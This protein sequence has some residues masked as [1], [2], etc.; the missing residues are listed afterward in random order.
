[1]LKR[2]FTL[3]FNGLKQRRDDA[4]SRINHEGVIKDVYQEVEITP[5]YFLMLSL[6]NLIALTGLIV[7]SAPVIIGAML[8]S[9][10]MGPILSTGFAFATGNRTI[11]RRALRKVSVSVGLTLT[12]A[13]AASYL[14]PIQEITSEIA[15]RTRPNLFDLLIA[16][17]AGLAGAIAICTK[18]NYITIVPGVAIA[19]AVIPPLSVAGFGLG[20]GDFMVMAGG[21]FL[22]FT[23]FVAIIISTCGVLYFFGF[24]PAADSGLDRS[25]VRKRMTFLA[26]V[27]CVISVPLVYTL[28]RSVS[29]LGRKKTVMTALKSRFDRPGVSRLATFTLRDQAG[30]PIEIDAVINTIRYLSEREIDLAEKGIRASFGQPV[31]LNLEQIRVQPGGLKEETQVKPLITPVQMKPRLPAEIVTDAR[32]ELMP[33]LKAATER[34]TGVISPAV[35]TGFS[36]GFSSRGSGTYLALRIN[37][38]YPLSGD[39]ARLLENLVS[40]E[41]GVPV[42]LRVETVPFVPALVFQGDAVAITDEMGRTLLAAR[43]VFERAPDMTVTVATWPAYPANRERNRLAARRRAESVALFLTENCKIPRDRIRI[44]A[45][46]P[47]KGAGPAV[48]VRILPPDYL[49]QKPPVGP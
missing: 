39:E 13:A 5:G 27:L 6:A 31:V 20:T 40:S 11:W 35:V 8:I 1:M 18:K 14:S 46:P 42:T 38:D 4:A 17:F 10:L 28:H 47:E 26:V 3:L 30:K 36:V 16:I 43:S 41:L 48:T 45:M 44:S 33:L 12:V 9:P 32:R 2:L 25:S 34:I 24:S 37:R 29:E 23:N 15:A 21:F 19:T 7:N 22:F 49:P